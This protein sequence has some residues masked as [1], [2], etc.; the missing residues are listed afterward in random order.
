MAYMSGQRVIDSTLFDKTS[1][2][3]EE[4]Q[5]ASAGQTVFTTTYTYAAG[6]GTL[7]VLVNGTKVLRN[8]DY[9]ETDDTTITFLYGLSLNDEVTFQILKT[10]ALTAVGSG[11]VHKEL[12]SGS[13][14]QTVFSI[15]YPIGP[16]TN[17]DVYIN[18]V[19][20]QS[21][22]YSVLGDEITFID[23]PIAG[24]NNIEFVISDT[25]PVGETSADLVAFNP[26]LTY[27]AGTVGYYLKQALGV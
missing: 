23:A 8:V 12:R 26:S 7:N 18:G 6:M 15:G 21:N 19:Y 20:Q 14:S 13:G 1:A 3:N 11:E 22:T 27:P 4:T 10:T 25:L 2:F 24:T 17:I 16:K 5:L 9:T